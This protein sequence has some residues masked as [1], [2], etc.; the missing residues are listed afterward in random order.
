MC[1]RS[2]HNFSTL[3]AT[4]LLYRNKQVNPNYAFDVVKILTQCVNVTL[5]DKWIRM[6]KSDREAEELLVVKPSAEAILDSEWNTQGG[7]RGTS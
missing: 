7:T 6:E 4:Q 1:T 3:P 2:R 5:G